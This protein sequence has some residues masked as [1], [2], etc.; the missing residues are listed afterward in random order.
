MSKLDIIRDELREQELDTAVTPD[1]QKPRVLI[2]ADEGISPKLREVLITAGDV[3][4]ASP[5]ATVNNL[6]RLKETLPYPVKSNEGL[7]SPRR[8]KE[9]KRA[10]KKQRQ[11]SLPSWRRP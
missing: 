2:L 8:N 11:A 9:I 4:I 7:I 10:M 1:H 3:I 5:N 6:E